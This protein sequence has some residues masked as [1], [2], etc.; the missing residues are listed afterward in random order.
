MVALD[1]LKVKMG[2]PFTQAKAVKTARRVDVD[3]V[4]MATSEASAA[5][6]ELAAVPRLCP[7]DAKE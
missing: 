6:L 2:S 3:P 7:L 4:V 5:K 1:S